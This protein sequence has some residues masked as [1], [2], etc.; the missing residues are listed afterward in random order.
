MLL[1]LRQHLLMAQI[2]ESFEDFLLRVARRATARLVLAEAD[3]SISA[4]E[5]D[6]KDDLLAKI[7][8][9]ARLR[10]ALDLHIHDLIVYGQDRQEAV[11]TETLGVHRDRPTWKEIG[12]ALGVSGQAAHRKYGGVRRRT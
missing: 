12:E 9:A 11:L 5:A 10:R 7:R 1:R 6:D 8:M 3:N 4:A 2:T